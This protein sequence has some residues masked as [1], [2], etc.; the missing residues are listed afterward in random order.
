M[1]AVSD[2]QSVDALS[3]VMAVES[4]WVNQSLEKEPRFASQFLGL[5]QVT[6]RESVSRPSAQ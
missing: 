5:K 6:A 3:S 1:S 2:W 4:G